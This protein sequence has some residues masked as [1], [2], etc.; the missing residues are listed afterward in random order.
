MI[1]IAIPGEYFFEFP[2]REKVIGITDDTPIP[3]NEK[4]IKTGQ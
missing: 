4:P 3:T 1:D 2:A